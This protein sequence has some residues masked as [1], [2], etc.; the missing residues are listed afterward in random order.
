MRTL[1]VYESLYGNTHATA[2]QIAEGL[3]AAGEVAVVPVAAV[4]PEQVAAADLLVVGGPTHIHGLSS[5]RSRKMAIDAAA[6]DDSDV[7]LDPDAEGPGVRTWLHGLG[8]GDGRRAA[9]FDTRMPGRTGFTGRAS[10]G[11]ARRLRHHG[12]HVIADPE[13]FLVDKESHL[14]PGETERAKLWGAAL[15][16]ALLEAD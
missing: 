1:V 13:S 5:S 11:I 8:D 12:F 3:S 10:R 6:G 9:A 2:E 14:E 7:D 16:S 15:C 4:T